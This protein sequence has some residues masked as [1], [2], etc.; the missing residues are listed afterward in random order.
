VFAV[1]TDYRVL[2]R[3]DGVNRAD[4]AIQ[5]PHLN[6]RTGF[7]VFGFQRRDNHDVG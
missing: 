6:H 1:K 2:T 3:L 4:M 5:D 7:P